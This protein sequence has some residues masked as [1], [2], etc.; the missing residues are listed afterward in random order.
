[1]ETLTGLGVALRGLQTT[2]MSSFDQLERT[3][4]R[5]W[6]PQINAILDFSHSTKRGQARV[7][8]SMVFDQF[9]SLSV[10]V[11]G[12]TAEKFLSLFHRSRPHPA[13]A[14]ARSP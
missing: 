8:V 9:W 3:N 5:R 1:M 14:A 2:K 7:A 6:R 4:Y 12:P 11:F 13:I 10:S